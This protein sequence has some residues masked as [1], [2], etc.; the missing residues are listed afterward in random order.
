MQCKHEIIIINKHNSRLI[1]CICAMSYINA[2]CVCTVCSYICLS[3]AHGAG[4]LNGQISGKYTHFIHFPN[5]L[6]IRHVHYHY[7]CRWLYI[8]AYIHYYN[9]HS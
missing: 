5:Q 8:N 1:I 3:I 6:R 2:L 7:H 4:H 9:T